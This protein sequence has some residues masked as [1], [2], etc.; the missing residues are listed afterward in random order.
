MHRN[1]YRLNKLENGPGPRK[2]N[3]GKL[4]RQR[5]GLIEYIALIKYLHSHQY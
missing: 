5:P 1:S 2:M 4:P 3:F